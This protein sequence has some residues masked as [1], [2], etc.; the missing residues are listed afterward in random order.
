MSKLWHM[1]KTMLVLIQCVISLCSKAYPSYT[2]L[3]NAAREG[4]GDGSNFSS[5]IATDGLNCLLQLRRN[6]KQACLQ[7]PYRPGGW[8][9]P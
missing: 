2:G 4:G 6:G 7:H 1:H 9:L 3:L 8:R 5:R